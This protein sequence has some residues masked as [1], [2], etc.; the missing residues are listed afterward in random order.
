MNTDLE[1]TEHMQTEEQDQT[2]KQ[3]TETERVD[4]LK[5]RHEEDQVMQPALNDLAQK[6]AEL[7]A[8]EEALLQRERRFHAREN[9]L[10]LGLPEE[11]LSHVDYGSD[12]AVAS[13]L[14]IAALASRHP[15]ALP[16][17]PVPQ[18]TKPPSPAFASYLE[19]ARL[20]MEDPEGYK[21][22]ADP[23]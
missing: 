20:F 17:L 21:Q 16:A 11:I 13:A 10:A 3:L 7:T 2:A 1:K 23:S 18:Q 9:L 8:R 22:L 5:S 14:R 12:S 19:R 4:V 15:S 6:E